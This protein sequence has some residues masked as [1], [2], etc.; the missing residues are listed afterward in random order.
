MS[1]C[2]CVSIHQTEHGILERFGKFVGVLHPGLS[3]IGWPC[4]KVVGLVSTKIQQL[5]LDDTAKTEDNV[6]VKFRIAI[7]Y[8]IP[9]ASIYDAYYSMENPTDQIRSHVE[10]VN[11]TQISQIMYNH[12]FAEKQ[13]L[14]NAIKDELS[15]HLGGL[16]YQILDVQFLD[17]TLPAEL[18]HNMNLRSEAERSRE[19]EVYQAETEKLVAIKK[20]E[21]EGAAAIKMAES[22]AETQRLHGEGIAAQRKAILKGL[23]E[24][25]RDLS[26]TI[27]ITPEDTMKYT[28]TAQYFDMLKEIGSNNK[29]STLFLPHS[30]SSANEAS[31]QLRQT[32]LEVQA[33]SMNKN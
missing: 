22:N 29:N 8:Q 17:I 28:L 2:C 6:F 1:C 11:R 21:A 20:A 3:C 7:K 33:V 5:I 18:V 15:G 32:M 10:N 23:E 25:V 24:G 19:V 12:L 27:K 4:S 30:P 31:N 9:E 14:S 26:G 13:V 16:G